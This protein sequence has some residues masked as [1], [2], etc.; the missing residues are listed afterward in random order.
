[1]ASNKLKLTDEQKKLAAKFLASSNTGLLGSM[2]FPVPKTKSD[3]LQVYDK[4]DY[5]YANELGEGL[6]EELKMWLKDCNPRRK[7]YAYTIKVV[8]EEI[9]FIL[10]D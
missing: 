9:P 8:Q 5:E 10:E 3:I 2:D 6:E 7:G 1:M 4:V